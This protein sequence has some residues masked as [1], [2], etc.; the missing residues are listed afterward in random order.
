M[1]AEFS[2]DSAWMVDRGYESCSCPLHLAA[3]S[4]CLDIPDR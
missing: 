4:D 3:L 2:C 1:T